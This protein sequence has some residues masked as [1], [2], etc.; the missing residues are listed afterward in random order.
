[1]ISCLSCCHHWDVPVLNA[2]INAFTASYRVANSY[3]CKQE[4]YEWYANLNKRLKHTSLE[5]IIKP[6]QIQLVKLNELIF[7]H[8]AGCQIWVMFQLLILVPWLS[9][10]T[11]F[12]AGS[13]QFFWW[14]CV[15][16]QNLRSV[17][18]LPL[19]LLLDRVLLCDRVLLRLRS[20]SLS[21]SRSRMR[22]LLQLR[23]RLRL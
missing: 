6:D 2:Q 15:H 5:T 21:L 22:S 1:M 9:I 13:N 23:L 12:Q 4:H 18:F 7:E 8:T 10:K 16:R 20:L 11:V 3:I 17:R 19:L 14:S